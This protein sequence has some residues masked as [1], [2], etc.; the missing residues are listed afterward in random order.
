MRNWLRQQPQNVLNAARRWVQ[1]V[2]DRIGTAARAASATV[3]PVART[4]AAV[5][6]VA[7]R[8][9]TERV[10]RKVQPV[11]D[12]IGTAARATSAAVQPVART[13]AA[14]SPI[15]VRAGTERV[16]QR[17]QP[18]ADAIDTSARVAT[19]VAR[20]VTEPARSAAS[21]VMAAGQAHAAKTEAAERQRAEQE[22]AVNEQITARVMRGAGAAVQKG[23][24]FVESPP[25]RI[26][27]MFAGQQVGKKVDVLV[28]PARAVNPSVPSYE[29]RFAR[30]PED[31]AKG[32]VIGASIAI[33]AGVVG[34][35]LARGG[36][37]AVGRLAAGR[38]AQNVIR[39]GGGGAGYVTPAKT[40]IEEVIRLAGP[41]ATLIGATR[42]G[43]PETRTASGELPTGMPDWMN[44]WSDPHG[45]IGYAPDPELEVPDLT[46][47]GERYSGEDFGDYLRYR[48]ELSRREGPVRREGPTPYYQ[49][50]E[51]L[52]GGRTVRSPEMRPGEGILRGPELPT[53]GRTVRSP[54][55]AR[56]LE[57]LQSRPERLMPREGPILPT[58]IAAGSALTRTP[59]R[60][61]RAPTREIVDD[62]RGRYSFGPDRPTLAPSREVPDLE[63][64]ETNA[65]RDLDPQFGSALSPP[66]PATV[67]RFSL[68][69]R[70]RPRDRSDSLPEWDASPLSLPDT[71]IG[72]EARARVGAGA[73]SGAATAT[74]TGT[75]AG[76]QSGTGTGTIPDIANRFE[77]PPEYPTRTV[78]MPPGFETVVR[79]PPPQGRGGRRRRRVDEE[80]WKKKGR[81]RRTV[82]YDWIVENPVQDLES[83]FGRLPS[84]P[85]KRRR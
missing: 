44:E 58:D 65:A 16:T 78:E 77:F 32:V 61:G 57:P 2:T 1:P 6:P 17:V 38:S 18:V 85:P 75:R 83:M 63:A 28:T 62:G 4:V 10:K 82:S 49:G 76:I 55:I 41:G 24:E 15:V 35:G 59:P 46:D 56:V 60:R 79:P 69:A 74:R 30:H 54:E 64:W 31:L 13:A 26:G 48:G 25:A 71:G 84:G 21:T 47:R 20:P 50:P 51:I 68:E 81:R 53:G 8:A 34:G 43:Q 11:T 33:P 5:V 27:A 42:W 72:A 40:A 12:R 70:L 19:V 9:E 45:G 80:R 67:P 22:R 39:T 23:R 66:E 52:T 29:E 36:S 73:R 3:Q 37:L 7:T 14:V